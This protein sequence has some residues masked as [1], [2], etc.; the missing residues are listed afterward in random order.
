M[1]A[2][3]EAQLNIK[4]YIA[5]RSCVNCGHIKVCALFR[6]VAP[7]IESW[8]TEPPI[9]TEDLAVICTQFFSSQIA[10]TLSEAQ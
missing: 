7:L 5:K 10:K 4:N 2:Q 6:A 3:A 9:A 1:Q 8:K